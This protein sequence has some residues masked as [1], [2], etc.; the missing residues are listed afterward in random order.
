MRLLSV[1][2]PGRWRSGIQSSRTNDADDDRP[3]AD[4]E[5]EPAREPLV[6]HVPR[7]D[8]EAGQQQ[9][10]GAD[11]VEDE[12]GVELNQP[13]QTGRPSRLKSCREWPVQSRA[14]LLE[15]AR[16]DHSG[17]P[18]V[19][20]L[21]PWRRDGTSRE[22]LAARPALADPRR[23]ARG[24]EPATRGADPAD[25]ARRQP[26]HRDRRLR[27]AARAGLRREPAG[28]GKLGDASRRP[29]PGARTRSSGSR[30]STCGSPRCRRRPCSRSCSARPSASFPAGSTTTATTRSDCRRCAARSPRGSSGGGCPPA[31]SRSWSPNGALHALDLTIRATLPR[32]RRVL[33][34]LPS[35]PAALDA[36]RGAGARLTPAPLSRRAGMSRRSRRWPASSRPRWPT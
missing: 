34:E 20:L 12:P 23:P 16:G 14:N 13:A 24:G 31:P 32:G 1:P 27:P 17:Q 7:I 19:E 21:G 4:P 36:L 28:I 6:E 2:N 5:A 9:H 3:G 26:R 11:P 35:Y 22:R 18:I 8:A 15:V 33:V 29:P 10:R 25:G 30:A